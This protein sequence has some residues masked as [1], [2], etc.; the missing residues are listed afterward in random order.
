[1]NDLDST[2]LVIPLPWASRISAMPSLPGGGANQLQGLRTLLTAIQVN[3]G[4]LDADVDFGDG[5]KRPLRSAVSQVAP[6]G[7]IDR[8]SR[9]QVAISQEALGWQNS[10]RPHLLL[11]TFHR[12][13]RYI[14]ELLD[15]LRAGPRS[16][17]DLNSSAA[18]YELVWSTLDQTRRRLTWF[19]GLG[20]VEYVTT[21]Q[22]GL[23]AAGFAE[24]KLLQLGGPQVRPRAAENPATVPNV[25][26]SIDRLVSELNPQRL[27][28][29]NPVLGYIP[30]GKGETDVVE[31]LTMLVNACSPQIPRSNLQSFAKDAFGLSESSFGAV[32]TTLTKA[33]LIEQT[34]FNVYSPTAPAS[35]WL[36]EPTAFNLALILHAKFS[37]FLEIIPLLGEF[38]KA[39]DLARVGVEQFGLGRVDTGGIRTRLQVL[40]A[41]GLVEERSNW[42]FQAT[43]LGERLVLEVPV[44][45]SS[46]L[47]EPDDG[48]SPQDDPG[49]ESRGVAIARE[50]M[51]AGVAAETP[52]RL[53]VAVVDALTWLGFTAQ[54]IGGA[55][56]TDV[57]ATFE[58]VDGK[59]VRAIID[60]KA[61]R[62]GI[63]AESAVSFDTLADHKKHHQADLVSLV[64]PS[65]DGGRVKSRAA[66]NEVALITTAELSDAVRRQ[67]RTPVSPEVLL[68]LLD[69]RSEARRELETEWRGIERR[70]A[71]MAQ[72]VAVL[73]NEGRQADQVTH[74]ALTSDQ[75]YLIARTEL[76]P[77]PSPKDIEDVLRLLEHPLLASVR[78]LDGKGTRGGAF[79]LVDNPTLVAA[80]LDALA[81]SL[82]E[83]A[84]E[85]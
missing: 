31:A 4:R 82:A 25:P 34:G 28:A 5:I 54:H 52:A 19:A 37:F 38:D 10:G 58:S 63:V 36:E 68:K 61:S 80:K 6:A 41:A 57:M 66:Q 73:A 76:D 62:S 81:R 53:E 50:L 44:Q 55:G 65:F 56:K 60:T 1:M 21:T 67:E 71:L 24:L 69:S 11:A 16:V 43:P 48:A 70:V 22:I 9:N 7:L 15:Q 72:V 3:D 39:P 27:L 46:D 35:A 51:A 29:R 49:S 12:H 77:P 20:L 78:R 84:P 2:Q 75:I 64:G 26:P 30:R 40:R 47:T 23:T 45:A 18:T 14:G 32:L 79:V 13:I 85:P 17:R 8:I 74:G 33:G 59:T 42:R 83:V